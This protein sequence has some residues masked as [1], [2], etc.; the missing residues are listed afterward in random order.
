MREKSENCYSKTSR[1]WASRT[2]DWKMIWEVRKGILAKGSSSRRAPKESSNKPKS[3]QK[4][5]EGWQSIGRSRPKSL[6]AR[7]LRKGECGKT[8]TKQIRKSIPR[9]HGVKAQIKGWKDRAG[10]VVGRKSINP[11][12]PPHDGIIPSRAQKLHHWTPRGEYLLERAIWKGSQWSGGWQG[13]LENTVP[14]M[15]ALHLTYYQANLQGNPQGP[16]HA[17]EDENTLSRG[18]PYWEEWTA[19]GELPRRSQKSLW[20]SEN[21]LWIQL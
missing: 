9:D 11:E 7:W 10:W 14:R 15:T 17:W 20:P 19:I 16:W 12:C 1:N 6:E 3:K 5:N 8:S 21:I 4:N 13:G 18:C 2:E